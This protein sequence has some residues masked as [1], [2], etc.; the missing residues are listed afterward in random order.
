LIE[1]PKYLAPSNFLAYEHQIQHNAT[2]YLELETLYKASS[3][4]IR[5]STM[6]TLQKW[7]EKLQA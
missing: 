6:R 2:K 7:H 3:Q 4:A 5:H 1:Q